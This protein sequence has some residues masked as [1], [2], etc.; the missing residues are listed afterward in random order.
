MKAKPTD[1]HRGQSLRP[2]AARNKVT[3]GEQGRRGWLPQDGTRSPGSE[4]RHWLADVSARFGAWGP[5]VSNNVACP[6]LGTHPAA[7]ALGQSEAESPEGR[8][9]RG[10]LSE[11]RGNA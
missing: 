7:G 5:G 9:G 6:Q 10:R 1:S 3:A 2:L 8:G 4:C 11:H